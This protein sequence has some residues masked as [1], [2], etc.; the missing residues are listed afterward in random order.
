MALALFILMQEKNIDIWKRNL[1]SG[2]ENGGMVLA[3]RHL[4]YM[5]FDWGDKAEIRCQ[6]SEVRGQKIRR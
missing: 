5:D 2:A 1:E 6:M 3:N 4:D